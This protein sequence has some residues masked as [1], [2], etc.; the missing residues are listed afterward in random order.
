MINLTTIDITNP[1]KPMIITPIADIFEI[2]KNSSFVG[3]LS[4][5]HTLKHLFKKL[6]ALNTI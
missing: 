5:C 2:V 6:L 3:F 1:T 4:M